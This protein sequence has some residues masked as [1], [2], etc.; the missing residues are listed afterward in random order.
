MQVRAK[1]KLTKV[2]RTQHLQ[3]DGKDEQ[4]R[5]RYSPTE[6]HTLV[7]QPVYHSND[8]QHE[9]YKFWKATPS[10]ELKLGT[11]LPEVAEQFVIGQEYYIDFTPA[12]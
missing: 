10:G 11:V 3:L 2:E 8:T 9:N 5:D 6:M 4:G 1:F 12:E 7:M